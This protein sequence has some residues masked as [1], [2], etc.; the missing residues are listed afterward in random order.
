MHLENYIETDLSNVT[1]TVLSGYVIYEIEDLDK[2]QS[3][4][5][6]LSKGKFYKM[7][8]GRFHKV[9]TIGLSPSVYMYTYF[10]QTRRE[11]QLS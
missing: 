6:L 1:L 4:G 7:E 3:V 2:K 10:N 11:L 5:I 9:H 8:I